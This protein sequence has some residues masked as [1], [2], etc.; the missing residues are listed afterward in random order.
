M[1]GTTPMAKLLP[2][3]SASPSSPACNTRQLRRKCD[4]EFREGADRTRTARPGVRAMAR[5]GVADEVELKELRTQNAELGW[6]ALSS[7]DRSFYG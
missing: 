1:T 3:S 6:N 7:S 5:V 2:A 4:S